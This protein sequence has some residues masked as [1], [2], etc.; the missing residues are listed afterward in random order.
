M[1][2][3]LLAEIARTS[4]EVAATSS[5]LQKTSRLAECLGRASPEEIA[6][7]V[8]YLSGELPQGTVGV[9]WAA[10]RDLPPAASEAGLGLLEA[11]AAVSRIQAISGKGSQATRREELG[12]LFGRATEEEQRLLTGLFLGELRQGALEGVMA[13]AFATASAMTCGGRRCSRGAFP[14]SLPPR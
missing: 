10:L 6:T 12:A 7:A 11:D 3:M 9:G 14:R 2:S 8:S 1:A 13:A 5:R 4:A